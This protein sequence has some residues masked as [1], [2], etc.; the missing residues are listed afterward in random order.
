MPQTIQNDAGEDVEVFTAEELEAQKTAALEEYKTA[1]PDKAEEM[2]KLQEELAKF[3][4]KDLNFG[5]LRD[6]KEGVEKKLA[7]LLAGVDEKIVTAKKEI[8]EGVL[9]D[10]FNETL[11]SLAG[12]DAELQK[13]IELHY[14]RLTDSAV[15]KQEVASK[16]RDAWVLATKQDDPGALSTAVISSGDVSKLPYKSGDK[17]LS[18]EEKELGAKFGITAEDLN[19]YGQ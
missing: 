3:K 14:N 13:K 2:A 8:L 9:K 12:E 5:N 7:D 11:K 19:K 18:P 4:A 1:N 16:L 10:H 6:Q 17:K 15:T